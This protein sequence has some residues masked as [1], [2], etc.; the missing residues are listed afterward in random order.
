MST[1]SYLSLRQ[2]ACAR[3]FWWMWGWQ[4]KKFPAC[5][6]W[7]PYDTLNLRNWTFLWLCLFDLINKFSCSFCISNKLDFKEELNINVEVLES[8][9]ESKVT[10]AIPLSSEARSESGTSGSTISTSA[11]ATQ[12]QLPRVTE[13]VTPKY[14]ETASTTE[15]SFDTASKPQT[16]DPNLPCVTLTPLPQS[17]TLTPLPTESIPSSNNLP[18]TSSLD[19]FWVIS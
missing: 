10:G 14:K 13:T 4:G 8:Q 1:N 3:S 6:G 15:S 5:T 2:T 19:N 9:N 16:P 11:V 7:F 17:V 18:P 12:Q